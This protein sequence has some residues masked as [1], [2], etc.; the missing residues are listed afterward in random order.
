[1]RLIH[2]HSTVLN[3]FSKES[4]NEKTFMALKACRECKKKVSTEAKVCPRCGVPDPTL[5]RK[6]KSKRNL[7]GTGAGGWPK[8]YLEAQ[9]ELHGSSDGNE[10]NRYVE[11]S[12]RDEF[13]KNKVKNI[14]AHCSNKKCQTFSKLYR[15]PFTSVGSRVCPT[16]KEYLI[17]EGGTSLGAGL[18]KNKA[19]YKS[20]TKGF[21]TGSEGLAK[22][23]WL[24]FI[25]G[26]I[27]GN[28]LLIFAGNAGTGM[29]TFVV[30]VIACWTIA[31]TIGIFNAADIYKE[32]KTR[33]GQTFGYATAAKAGTVVLIL[34]AIGNAL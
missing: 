10:F 18:T 28:I 27:V 3:T 7:K 13:T 14:S 25:G 33:A 19:N 31:A 24:Y 8:E 22:T 20:E 15:I 2:I 6:I 32:E 4:L 1:M 26:N 34:S 30:I 11:S 23:F 17:E 29:V 16:C 12:D 21:W 9:A 5:K